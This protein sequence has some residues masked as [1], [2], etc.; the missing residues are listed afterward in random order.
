MPRRR[1][2]PEAI[3]LPE[4]LQKKIAFRSSHGVSLVGDSGHVLDELLDSGVGGRV[5][6]VFTSPPFPLN[7]KKQYD[8]LQ[9]AAFKTWLADYAQKLRKLLAPDGSIVIEMGNAWEPDRPVMSTLA[10]ESLLQFKQAGDL[11]LCQEFVWHNPARL[12]SPA[13]WV[14]VERIRVKDSFTKVWWLSPAAKPKADNRRVL[15][16][17]SPA[18]KRLLKRKKYNAGVRPSEHV[19]GEKSFFKDNGGAI[20]PSVLSVEHIEPES[21]LVGSNT[22]TSPEYLEFCEKHELQ[23]HPARMPKELA[24]FFIKL[25]TEPG[26][27]VLDPFAG[28]NTTGATAEDLNRR[29][30]SIEAQPEYAL[31]AVSRFPSLLKRKARKAQVTKK[32]KR[33]VKKRKTAAKKIAKQKELARKRRAK[34]SSGRRRAHAA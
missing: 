14:T 30:V 21:V 29:W 7:R 19:I 33:L 10:L 4:I 11:F 23:Q 2:K 28:S 8:N 16:P 34:K 15:S 12:P 27:L 9:G 22:H 32:I 3:A 25:C 24:A 5:Q 20:P 1:T 6:L 17:Y 26:D 18:M 13:Q 31:A